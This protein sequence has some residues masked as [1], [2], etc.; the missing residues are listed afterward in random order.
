[1]SCDEAERLWTACLNAGIA[2]RDSEKRELIS[3]IRRDPQFCK[4]EEDIEVT[5]RSYEHCKSA[6]GGHLANHGCWKNPG[7]DA[8]SF[9]VGNS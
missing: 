5:K 9:S 1:V 6:F 4:F 3:L 2:Y 7:R 8:L